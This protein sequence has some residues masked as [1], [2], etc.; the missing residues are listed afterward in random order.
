LSDLTG[1]DMLVI[2]DEREVTM[3]IPCPDCTAELDHCHGSLVVH[4]DA[5]VECTEPGCVDLDRV[6]HALAVLACEE[7]DGACTCVVELAEL[8][9]AS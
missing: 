9:V 4:L 5:A 6:R 7:V 1:N 8:L 2:T 3:S